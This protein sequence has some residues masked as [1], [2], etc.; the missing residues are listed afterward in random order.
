VAGTNVSG[1]DAASIFRVKTEAAWWK[2]QAYF[3]IIKILKRL[4]WK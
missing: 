3:S 4:D 1:W 2:L